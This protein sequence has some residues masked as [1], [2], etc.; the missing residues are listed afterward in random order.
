MK[1]KI[2]ETEEIYHIIRVY[3]D[4]DSFEDM[5]YCKEHKPKEEIKNGN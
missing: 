4:E 2:C 5:C 1:C 3:N